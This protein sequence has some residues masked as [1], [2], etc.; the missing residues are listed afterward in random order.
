MTH[1]NT[2]TGIL[3]NTADRLFAA[4]VLPLLVGLALLASGTARAAPDAVFD[5]IAAEILAGIESADVT[6]VPVLSGYGAPSIGVRPFTRED[7][8]V[9]LDVADEYN[10]WLLARLQA[11][12]RGRF[13]FVALDSIDT[14]IDDI[15][16]TAGSD[17]EAAMRIAALRANAR[18]DVLIAGTIRLDGGIPVLSYHAVGADNGRLLAATTPRRMA[19]PGIRRALSDDW[20]PPALRRATVDDL[21]PPI[22]RRIQARYR[23][24][25]AEAERLLWNLGYDPGPVDGIMT[26]ETRAAL[27]A[28]QADS[29]LPVTGRMTRRVVENMRRDTR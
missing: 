16:A 21:P 12:G 22:S 29:A 24:A 9:P 8:A 18:A 1:R 23:R 25:I 2:S 11:Q 6:E 20:S 5:D 3:A 27:R 19:P 14:L 10:R 26:A 17:E 4:L 13:T 7:A 28:Y 15:E